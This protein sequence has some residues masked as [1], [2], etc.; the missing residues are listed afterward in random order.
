MTALRATEAAGDQSTRE[1]LLAAATAVFAEQ[2]YD[3]ARVQEIARRAGLTTGAIYGRFRDKAELLMEAISARSADELDELITPDRPARSARDVLSAMG[4]EL[5][6]AP[7]TER[8]ALLIE[9]L[10]AARRDGDVAA[11]V[12]GTVAEQARE[13]TATVEH[14]RREGAIADAIDTDAF[15]TFGLALAFGSLL[16]KAI[17]LARPDQDS[18]AVLINRLVSALG[19]ET[20]R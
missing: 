17:G 14:A 7:P 18:W 5:M 4:R 1:R 3:G 8:G 11:M 15:V 6:A 20:E 2:G 12:R 10:V 16:F 13:L 9:A 19:D